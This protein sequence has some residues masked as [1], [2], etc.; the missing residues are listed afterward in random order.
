MI[1]LKTSKPWTFLGAI[2]SSYTF[3]H[4]YMKNTYHRARNNKN[5]LIEFT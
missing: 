1:Y 4:V 3:V 2:L 5:A